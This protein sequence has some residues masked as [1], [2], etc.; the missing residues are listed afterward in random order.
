MDVEGC[1]GSVYMMAITVAVSRAVSF[2]SVA[3]FPISEWFHTTFPLLPH[4][5][6]HYSPIPPCPIA[7]RLTFPLLAGI[8]SLHFP[9]PPLPTSQS[10]TSFRLP[11]IYRDKLPSPENFASFFSCHQTCPLLSILHHRRQRLPKRFPNP[12]SE[13]S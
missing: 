12:V 5:H 7:G 10:A 4:A 8:G 6:S 9:F 3:T 2:N 1:R 11:K 13:F